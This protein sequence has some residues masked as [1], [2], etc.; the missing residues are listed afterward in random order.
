MN[1]NFKILIFLYTLLITASTIKAQTNT[2]GLILNDSAKSFNGYTLFSPIPSTNSYLIDNKGYMIHEWTSQY[3]PAQSVMLLPD[4]SLLRPAIIQ[5]GNIFLAGGAGGRVEKYDW[6]GNLIWSFDYYSAEHC[7]HHDLEYLPNGDILM[8]A[9][10]NKSY[11]EAVAAG[12][13]PARLDTALWAG[14]IIEVKPTGTS[15]GDIVWQWHSWDHLI[16]DFDSTKSN[17]GDVSKHPELI[18]INY[19]STIE[20]WLHI[21]SIRYN[22]ER[23]EILLSAHNFNE[24]WVID[25]STTTVEAAGHSGGREGKGGDLLY[26]WGNPQAYRAG[27]AADQKLFSQHDARWIDS[28]FVGQGDI[29]IFN[30]D[31]GAPPNAYSTVDEITPPI[32]S[33]GDYYIDSTGQYGPKSLTWTYEALPPTLFFAKNISGEERLPNG[34]TLICDGTA[35]RFFELDNSENIVWEYVNPVTRNGI[36]T[37]GDAPSFNLVFKIYRYSPQYSGLA[38]KDLTEKGKIELY[39]S[40]VKNNEALPLKFSLGQNYP[41]PFNPSTKISYQLS[42]QRHVELDVYNVL[43]EKVAELVNKEQTSGNYEVT[44][45]ASNMTSGIYFY[46][47]KAGNFVFT[48]KMILMK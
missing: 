14:E 11:A 48:K 46:Q 43:G 24:I 9:W 38:G 45:D 12:R 34:N 28:G 22:P 17:Y 36:L 15:G 19:G 16:Q 1:R 23:D 33:N 35:G 5:S 21:N 2:V 30:N 37:Q 7:T 8:I 27:T 4:G 31:H 41:N 40:A 6:N 29:L 3:R 20:D 13:N 18:D 44:L 10:E 26:R 25:H 32:N 47:L 39:P 42:A